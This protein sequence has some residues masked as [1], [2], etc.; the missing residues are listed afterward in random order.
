MI[1]YI[2]TPITSVEQAEALPEGT[3]YFD[4]PGKW[5]FRRYDNG[6]VEALAEDLADGVVVTA[7]VPI[8]AHTQDPGPTPGWGEHVR[9]HRY[10]TEWRYGP[11]PDRRGD[12]A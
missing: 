9:R 6:K 3:L 2:P 5:M 1:V 7:L 12:C 11:S 4:V 8:E 10:V